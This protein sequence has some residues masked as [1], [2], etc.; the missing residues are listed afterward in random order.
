MVGAA[1]ATVASENDITY[2]QLSDVRGLKAGL[3]FASIYSPAVL[4]AEDI[5]RATSGERSPELDAILN[6]LDGVDTKGRDVLTV[7]TTNHPDK[8]NKAMLRPGRLDACIRIGPPDGATAA[9][10]L[11][12]H[13]GLSVEECAIAGEILRGHIPARLVET[14]KRAALFALTL[15]EGASST[16]SGEALAHAAKAVVEEAKIGDGVHRDPTHAE[17]LGGAFE[18]MV[19]SRIHDTL[20]STEILD[21]DGDLWGSMSIKSSV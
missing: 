10:L 9:R 11:A 20:E 5:D 6:T 2:I 15:T 16:V 14:T 17:A 21:N 8:L 19:A 7:L 3:A 4:F 13:T 12:R 18:K 1:T